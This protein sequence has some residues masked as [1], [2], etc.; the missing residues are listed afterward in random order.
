MSSSAVSKWCAVIVGH[1][2]LALMTS[3]MR[4]VLIVGVDAFE[5][6]GSRHRPQ[7]AGEFV[8]VVSHS[9]AF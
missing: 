1:G 6:P 3:S 5:D 8:L 2:P 7:D 4:L 9:K